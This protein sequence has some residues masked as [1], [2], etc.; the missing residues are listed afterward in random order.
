MRKSPIYEKDTK[1]PKVYL[2]SN[3]PSKCIKPKL[4]Q[5]EIE[6]STIILMRS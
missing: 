4:A 5:G 2:P 6:K 3:I 1:I